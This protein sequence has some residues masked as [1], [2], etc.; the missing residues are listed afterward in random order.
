MK[1][2]LLEKL[3]N[4]GLLNNLVKP[5]DWLLAE[6]HFGQES[7]WDS[8]KVG[9]FTKRIKRLDVF[10]SQYEHS[11]AKS[12]NFPLSS[13]PSDKKATIK[14]GKKDSEARDLIRHMRNSI[15]HSNADLVKL[16]DGYHLEMRDYTTGG[17]QTA[18]LL[19]KLELLEAAYG[20]YGEIEGQVLKRR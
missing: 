16:P 6:N 5:I 15:A 7:G 8:V 18:Y 12:I 3:Q 4:A 9:R 1:A 14:L 13:R 17:K 11:A 2:G 20:L 19:V 10:P